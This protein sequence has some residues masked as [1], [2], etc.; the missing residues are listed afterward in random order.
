MVT[1]RPG[2]VSSVLP[3]VP[4]AMSMTTEPGRMPSIAFR[5]SSSGARRPGT[6]AVVM[7]TSACAA[8]SAYRAAAAAAWSA[9]ICVAYPSRDSSCAAGRGTKLAPMDSTCSAT[10]G[11]TSVPRT[12]APSDRAAPIP[13]RPATP[14]PMT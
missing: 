7:T 8:S 13:A 6:A 3:P 14:A 9:A 5:P 1:T 2:T 10:S 11:R 12:T 4:A